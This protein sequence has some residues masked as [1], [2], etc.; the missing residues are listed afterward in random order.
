LNCRMSGLEAENYQSNP[1]LSQKAQTANNNGVA[2]DGSHFSERIFI[3]EADAGLGFIKKLPSIFFNGFTFVSEEVARIIDQ[4][5]A[6]ASKTY[7]VD[8]YQWDKK[9]KVPGNFKTLNFGNVKNCLIT[10][11]S[12]SI[13]QNP[14]IKHPHFTCRRSR[15][16]DGD[17]KVS[18]SALDGANIWIDPTLHHAFF[19]AGKLAE[20]L[21]AGGFQKDFAMK[22]CAIA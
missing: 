8:V 19:I 3:R 17:L 21:I 2:L 10:A 12:Q 1:E 11:E 22:R 13:E 4:H 9:T 5:N 15:L 16:K 14:Y 18:S 7:A 20:A 6:G